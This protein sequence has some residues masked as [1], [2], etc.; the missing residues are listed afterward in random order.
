MLQSLCN[1]S[2]SVR[3]REHFLLHGAA[4]VEWFDGNTTALSLDVL[5]SMSSRP[6]TPT[7]LQAQIEQVHMSM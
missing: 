1:D 6:N 3:I 7:G 4:I 5:C 2:L